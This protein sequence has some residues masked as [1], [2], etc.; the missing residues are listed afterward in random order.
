MGNLRTKIHLWRRILPLWRWVVLVDRKA[1][2]QGLRSSL[3]SNVMNKPSER[4]SLAGMLLSERNE[5]D[6]WRPSRTKAL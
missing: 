6:K 1:G 5:G 3:R 4:L 2:R